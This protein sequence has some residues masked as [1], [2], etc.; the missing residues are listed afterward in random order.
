M[1]EYQDLDHL[2]GVSISSISANL[3]NNERDDLAMFYFSDGA[4]FA[5][6]YTQV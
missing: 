1:M 6:L 4:N 2:D 3:Y 5:S